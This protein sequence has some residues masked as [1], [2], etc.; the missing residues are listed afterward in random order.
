[1]I[2]FLHARG[3]RGRGGGARKHL[4]NLYKFIIDDNDRDSDHD[5]GNEA[6][7]VMTLVIFTVMKNSNN[8]GYEVSCNI[9]KNDN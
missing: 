4:K 1:M 6:D 8:Y 3:G 5:Y 2:S 7:M 9:I